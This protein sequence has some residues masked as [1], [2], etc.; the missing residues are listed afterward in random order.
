META[1]LT[2]PRWSAIAR[3][4]CPRA[5]VYG[6]QGSPEEST[7]DREQARF[8]LGHVICNGYRADDVADLEAAG[9]TCTIEMPIPWPASDPVGT[10][11]ADLV[12]DGQHGR[13]VVEYTTNDD[14]DPDDAK[15]LQLIGYANNCGADMATLVVIA[16]APRRKGRVYRYA[17]DLA[18]HQD[19]VAR[20]LELEAAAA[21]AIRA[22]RADRVCQHPGDAI[23]RLCPHA[24]VCFADWEPT[25][26][27]ELI[28]LDQDL[29]RLADIKDELAELADQAEPLEDERA[30]ISSRV[31]RYLDEGQQ[32]RG[33]LESDGS[34]IVAKRIVTRRKTFSMSKANKLV[35]GWLQGR[36][37]QAVSES[38]SERLDIRRIGAS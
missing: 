32:V 14:G 16:I 12:V 13:L 36:L 2:G 9:H 27:D 24:G 1:V 4:G 34:C 7:S 38:V 31:A 8:K 21:E 33:G 37:T 28:G 30:E 15:L 10:G 19:L 22:G 20:A 35:P 29:H 25:P 23:G 17:F 3:T 5:G 26:L 11:H 6:A 18:E